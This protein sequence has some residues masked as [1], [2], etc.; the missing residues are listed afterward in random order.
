MQ[1]GKILSVHARL[2]V[3]SDGLE[4]CIVPSGPWTI[5]VDEAEALYPNRS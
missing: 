3:K 5:D 2:E 4:Y 1:E